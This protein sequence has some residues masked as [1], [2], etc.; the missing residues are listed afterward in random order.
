MVALEILD[1]YLDMR[2]SRRA[3]S[4]LGCLKACHVRSQKRSSERVLSRPAGMISS[5]F[6]PFFWFF[7]LFMLTTS[8]CL[9]SRIFVSIG[10]FVRDVQFLGSLFPEK[11]LLDL[12][13]VFMCLEQFFSWLLLIIWLC[14]SS[15]ILF[16]PFFSFTIYSFGWFSWPL[17]SQILGIRCLMIWTRFWVQTKIRRTIP[18]LD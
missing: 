11:K 9:L 10:N 7:F 14:A 18:F 6:L 13:L 5:R 15:F 4:L 2:L 8:G 12:R 3:H 17:V 1:L 16:Y